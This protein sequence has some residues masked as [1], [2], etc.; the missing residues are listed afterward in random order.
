MIRRLLNLKPP[1]KTPEST[2]TKPISELVSKPSQENKTI[3]YEWEKSGK[4]E[5]LNAR[6]KY[7]NDEYTSAGCSQL[8]I[9]ALAVAMGISNRG[10][11]PLE[12]Q[13]NDLVSRCEKIDGERTALKNYKAKL[14]S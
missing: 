14:G 5:T 9:F 1:K 4:M 6:E 3:S 12:I 10:A 11:S 13:F 7:L 2:N 8:G